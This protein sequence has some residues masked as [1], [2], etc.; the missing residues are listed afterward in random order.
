MFF[1][2]KQELELLERAYASEKSELVVLFGRRRIGK[3]SLVHTF[4][5]RKPDFIF[6]E[7]IEGE[8]TRTQIKHV[9]NSLRRQ[10]KDPLLAN[11]A[12]SSWDDL[13]SYITER[14]LSPRSTHKKILFLDE[15]PWLAAGRRKL[16][17]L[18]K[19]YWDNHWKKQKVMLILCGSLTAFMANKVIASKAL[20][21]RVSIEILLRHLAPSEARQ[22]FRNKRSTEEVLR[23][24]LIFGGIPKYLEEIDLSRSLAQNL[25][26]LCFSKNSP[27]SREV[28]RIFYSQF[29][30]PQTYLR[31]VKLLNTKICSMKEI[32]QR[33]SIASGGGL[34][35]YLRNLEAVEIIRSFCPFGS[36]PTSKLR[37]F[38]LS[39]EYL[40]FFFKYVEP[41]LRTIAQSRSTRLFETLTRDSLDS[42]LGFAFERF[43]LKY[44]AD[45]AEAMGFGE[46]LLF[47]APYFE[48]GDSRF[49][50]DLL[51]QR[52][53]KVITICE[54]KHHG[55]PITTKVI[56]EVERRCSLLKVPRGHT[57]ERALVSLYGPDTA[58]RDAG[59]FHHYLT[60]KELLGIGRR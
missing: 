50:I 31:I 40:L 34:R 3:S 20:Y 59:Y 57:V 49:Q 17:G 45:L 22:F 43:C 37:K 51:F 6:F 58:L 18:L 38:T 5:G 2:R 21:G 28:E 54:I 30:E 23:Y 36:P 7:G 14:V 26:Q 4:A 60:L 42:W 48:R 32:G 47:A 27:M 56:P 52:S 29:K 8:S 9:T 19:Y 53:D 11:V 35:Q 44:A 1:G 33:L 46:R 39:D 12:F 55:R 13:L 24:L 25:N 16:V 15:L 10:T 41:N